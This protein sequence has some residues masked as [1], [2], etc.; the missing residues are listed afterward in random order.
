VAR[1]DGRAEAGRVGAA[2]LK[3]LTQQRTARVVDAPASAGRAAR[4]TVPAEYE[5]VPQQQGRA[6]GERDADVTGMPGPGRD[7][8]RFRNVLEPRALTDRHGYGQHRLEA[9]EAGQCHRGRNGA[10]A[11]HGSRPHLDPQVQAVSADR[12]GRAADEVHRLGRTPQ[13]QRRLRPQHRQSRYAGARRLRDDR[14]LSHHV[15]A[16]IPGHGVRIRV[17]SRHGSFS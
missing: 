12:A 10:K 9:V 6:F 3:R 17:K 13:Y 5:L 1:E 15:V 4:L 11:Q 8:D 7:D 16:R 14:G 2:D